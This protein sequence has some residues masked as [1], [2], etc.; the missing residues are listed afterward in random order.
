MDAAV[1][2]AAVYRPPTLL[3]APTTGEPPKD[4]AVAS[5]DVPYPSA[6]I[7]PVYPPRAVQAATTVLLFEAAVD[8]TGAI[9]NIRAVASDPA[10]EGVAR[11]ALAQWKFR[12]AMF[13]ARL[14]PANVYVIVGFNP[15]VLSTPR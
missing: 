10:F 9:S 5:R 6:L 14:V 11:D 4:L 2:I 1:L 15:P 7:P 3:N 12:P 8:Q 13:R